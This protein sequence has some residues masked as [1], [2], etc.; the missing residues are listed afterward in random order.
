M[1]DILI[2]IALGAV[3]GSLAKALMPGADPGGFLKTILLGVGGAFAGGLI[4]R[5]TPLPFL[6]ESADASLSLGSI[7]HRHRR[8]GRVA[9]LVAPDEREEGVI[10][11]GSGT[12]PL[13]RAG[14]RRSRSLRRAS[15]T[16]RRLQEF[17]FLWPG[18]MAARDELI[19]TK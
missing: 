18:W 4:G 3:A 16:T 7:L 5:I 12:R 2:W 13:R 9:R 8:R 14:S 15:G 19:L 10:S 6:R 11:P 1:F 17:P